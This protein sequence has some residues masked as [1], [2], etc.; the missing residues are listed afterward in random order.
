M[1]AD[2]HQ[3]QNLVVTLQEAFLDAP[4]LRLTLSD[5]QQRFAADAR[6]CEAVLSFLVDAGVLART[7][8]GQYARHVPLSASRTAA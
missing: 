1:I 5:A 7:P 6:L 8:Q 4:A 2:R 3:I